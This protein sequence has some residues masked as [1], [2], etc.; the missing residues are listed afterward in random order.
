M[1]VYPMSNRDAM[2]SYMA[3]VPAA[4]VKFVDPALQQFFD[5]QAQG[6]CEIKIKR[7]NLDEIMTANAKGQEIQHTVEVSYLDP[8]LEFTRRLS[9]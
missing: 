6:L 3:R 7:L 4:N 9:C 8:E 1:I 5:D 2:R